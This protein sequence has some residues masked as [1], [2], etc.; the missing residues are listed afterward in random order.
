MNPAPLLSIVSGLL[1]LLMS[2]VFYVKSGS[3]QTLSEDLQKQQDSLA[4]E[5]RSFQTKQQVLQG[6]QQAVQG[7][8][9]LSE[10]I[11][12]QV[13]NDLGLLARDNKNEKIKKLLE[14]YDVK[15]N[16]KP[17]E[18]PKPA[19]NNPAPSSPASTPQPNE[20]PRLQ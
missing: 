11:G 5:Q 17:P 10:Q 15:I 2:V 13:L 6:Q 1:C 19:G 14:K 16:E 18:T 12:P 7:A 20:A 8:R 4:A 3:V 9:Q